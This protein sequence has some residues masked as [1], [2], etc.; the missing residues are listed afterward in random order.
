VIVVFEP[1]ICEAVDD[2]LFVH[3]GRQEV[4]ADVG[5]NVVNRSGGLE[6]A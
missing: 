5:R 6:L 1:A 2:V 3:Y 4:V